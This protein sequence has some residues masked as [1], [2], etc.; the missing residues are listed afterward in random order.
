MATSKARSDAQKS[1]R[2]QS[3]IDAAVELLS[4]NVSELPPVSAIAKQ[5]GFAKGTVYIYFDSKE[6]LFLDIYQDLYAKCVSNFRR[7]LHLRDI[8][9]VALFWFE[10]PIFSKLMSLADGMLISSLSTEDKKQYLLDR[11]NTLDNVLTNSQT[12]NVLKEERDRWY[13]MVKLT[14]SSIQLVWL[15]ESLYDEK[16]PKKEVFIAMAAD[17][18]KPVWDAYIKTTL[19]SKKSKPWHSFLQKNK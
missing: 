18:A 2:K 3:I 16:E 6:R 11:E 1:A 7:E 19:Q 8:Q 15:E 12:V 14:M 5:A 13:Q 4:G 10:Q 17:A 9:Q